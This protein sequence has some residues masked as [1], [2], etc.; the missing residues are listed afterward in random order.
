M[1]LQSILEQKLL[2]LFPDEA[3]RHEVQQ[4]L[5][6]YGT[7]GHEREAVRVRIA[8]LKLAGT[9]KSRV[10]YF[11]NLAKLDY[12]DI[13]GPAEYPAQ[14]RSPTWRLPESEK[15]PLI[16]QDLEQY[17]KWLRK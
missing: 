14:M 8:I 1:N 6:R 7:A 12:R 16:Q 5:A 3:Q 4:D 10:R 15:Q 17:E 11:V 9:D 2:K 13:L